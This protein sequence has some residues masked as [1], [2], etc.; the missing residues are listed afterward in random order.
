MYHTLEPST[1][2]DTR[3]HPP[4]RPSSSRQESS[5][6]RVLSRNRNAPRQREGW[7]TPTSSESGL[8]VSLSIFLARLVFAGGRA[9]Y[10][11]GELDPS[12]L[13]WL[14]GIRSPLPHVQISL[15]E[16]L[17]FLHPTPTGAPAEDPILQGTYVCSAGFG[18]PSRFADL[19]RTVSVT[20]YLPKR[21]VLEELT[22]HLLGRQSILL[23]DQHESSD[24]L[25]KEVSLCAENV[26]LEK[27]EHQF[28]FSII[29]PSSTPCWEKCTY[30]RV[31][32]TVQA[33]AKGL[34]QLGGD[35]ES[36]PHKLALIVNV[37]R[38]TFATYTRGGR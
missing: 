7:P 15:H 8:F 13:R 9:A 14:V 25:S 31:K 12:S 16:E 19:S 33:R 29:V 36:V 27:G 35:V 1:H 22:V 17:L 18:R 20:L 4:I 38:D 2:P 5:R 21:R 24:S 6:S 30:G 10:P 28:A 34:G 37:G 11:Q 23:G 32:H 26:A 3:L